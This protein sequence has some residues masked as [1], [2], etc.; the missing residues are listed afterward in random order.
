MI[1]DVTKTAA[2]N[3]PKDKT[4][5]LHLWH[6]WNNNGRKPEDLKPLVSQ[7]RGM[8]RSQAGQY[9]GRVELPPAA[10]NAEF[11]RHAVRAL[12]TFDP[13]KGTALGTW[14]YNGMKKSKSFIAQHQNVVRI[15]EKR[16]YNIGDFNNAKS[17]LSSSY[18]R[19]PT[20][21][22]LAD[23]LGWHTDEVVRLEKQQR[24]D[25]IGSELAVDP[26]EFL[27]SKEHELRAFLPHELDATELFVYEH[28]TGEN[29]KPRLSGN[30]IAKRLKVSPATVS[31]LKTGIARKAKRLMED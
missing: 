21:H 28:S 8:I 14:V 12:T 6:Q 3:G 11:K 13:N 7:F 27:P 18:G 16:L 9:V 1:V 5:D 25:L 15:S 26:I 20:T 24:S 2:T 17:Q 30:E 22:E 10:I 31:R 29:G 23:H 19:E 4:Q